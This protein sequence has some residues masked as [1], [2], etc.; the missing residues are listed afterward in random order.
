MTDNTTNSRD[1]SINDQFEIDGEDL[2]AL[3]SPVTGNAESV[4]KGDEE[5]RKQALAEIPIRISLCSRHRQ[6]RFC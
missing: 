5:H 4:E 6:P 3:V 2:L 1:F